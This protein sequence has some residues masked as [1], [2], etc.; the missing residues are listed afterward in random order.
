MAAIT[1]ITINRSIRGIAP[2][3]ELKAVPSEVRSVVTMPEKAFVTAAEAQTEDEPRAGRRQGKAGKE[4]P[5]DL[6]RG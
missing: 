3:T 4:G 5:R 2:A 1:V 6:G